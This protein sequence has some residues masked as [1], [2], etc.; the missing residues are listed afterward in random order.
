MT[1]Q[2][3]LVVLFVSLSLLLVVGDHSIEGIS[4]GKGPVAEPVKPREPTKSSEIIKEEIY[5]PKIELGLQADYQ[6]FRETN[7]TFGNSKYDKVISDFINSRGGIDFLGKESPN[8]MR[9]IMAEKQ[10][11]IYDLNLP[12]FLTQF[13]IPDLIL[14]VSILI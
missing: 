12:I 3:N 14:I 9:T 7:P 10:T 2:S 1:G 13:L 11:E 8:E 4:I 5:S 6:L